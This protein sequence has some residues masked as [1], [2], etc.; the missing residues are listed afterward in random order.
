MRAFFDNLLRVRITRFAVSLFIEN[1]EGFLLMRERPRPAGKKSH[2]VGHITV[3]LHTG[4]S[5]REWS[6]KDV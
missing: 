6:L 1:E 3:S 5:R 4:A 2:Q